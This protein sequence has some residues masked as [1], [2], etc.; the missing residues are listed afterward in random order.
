[1]CSSCPRDGLNN[2]FNFGMQDQNCQSCA[3]IYDRRN[4]GGDIYKVF[5]DMYCADYVAPIIPVTPV[6][7]PEPTPVEPAKNETEK[8]P[9]P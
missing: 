8:Q 5:Y 4:N 7:P 6:A 2:I 1:M 9:E 3:I